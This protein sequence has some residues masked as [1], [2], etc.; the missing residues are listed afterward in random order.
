MQ[1]NNHEYMLD[2]SSVLAKDISSCHKFNRHVYQHGEYKRIRKQYIHNQ[3]QG[4]K[5]ILNS[6]HADYELI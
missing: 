6:I 2:S 1:K 4:Y 5:R 3:R